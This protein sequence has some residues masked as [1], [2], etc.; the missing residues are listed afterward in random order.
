MVKYGSVSTKGDFTLPENTWQCLETLDAPGIQWAEA[1]ML[2][3]VLQS[4]GQPPPQKDDL[5]QNVTHAKLRTPGLDSFTHLGLQNVI[6]YSVI[7]FL[8]VNWHTC[9]KKNFLIKYLV[10]L[11]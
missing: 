6:F 1:R 3:N 8:F 11:R 4:T 9:I 5:T 7:Y 2:L 10:F